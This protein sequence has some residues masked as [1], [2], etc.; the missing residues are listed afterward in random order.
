MPGRTPGDGVFCPWASFVTCS[1]TSP[2]L[3]VF[4]P[5]GASCA[6][7][8]STP[9]LWWLWFGRGVFQY[10]KAMN[11]A[12]WV[13]EQL[14]VRLP[15]TSRALDNQQLLV[16]EGSQKVGSQRPSGRSAKML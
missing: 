2:T 16:V 8:G 6:T 14:G 11:A 7:A 9:Q 10:D 15:A 13:T 4:G 12:D 5:R 3:A 1:S